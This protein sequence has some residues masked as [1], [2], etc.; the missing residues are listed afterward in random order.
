MKLASLVGVRLFD[1]D[2][3]RLASH[4]A[5]TGQEA[6]QSMLI[7]DQDHLSRVSSCLE[8]AAHFHLSREEALDLVQ[9]QLACIIEHWDSIC[10]EA[11]LSAVDRSYLWRR[12]FFN[13]FAFDDLN[14][15]AAQLR[16]MA[17]EA[18]G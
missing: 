9:H 15:D 10:D 17:D 16:T 12:Q 11:G 4:I 13:P 5:R 8:A 2:S 18:R 6:S 7:A 14:G 1:P 3:E